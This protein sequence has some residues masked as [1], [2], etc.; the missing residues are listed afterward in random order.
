MSMDM[1]AEEL[2]I[3]PVEMRLRNAIKNPKPGKIYE[4]IN[5]LTMATC[6]VEECIE[7]TAEAS[8]GK[9]TKM[10]GQQGDKAMGWGSLVE[11]ILVGQS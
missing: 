6:G 3:D 8:T 5:K 11:A 2:G 9:N 4:T 1:I 7:K 10:K